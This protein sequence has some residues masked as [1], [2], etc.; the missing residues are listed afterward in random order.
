MLEHTFCHIHGIGRTGEQKLWDR[1]IHTWTD[2]LS[3]PNIVPR[4]SEHQIVSVLEQSLQAL[5]DDPMFFIKRLKHGDRWRIYPHFRDRIGYIDIETTGLGPGCDITT[6][7]LYDGNLV[8]T[9]VNGENIDDF[10]DDVNE[11]SMFVSFNGLSFDIPVI[12]HFFRI[13]LDQAHLDLRYVLS[14][15]GFKGGLKKCERQLGINRGSLDGI[16]G[17][18]AVL[19]WREYERTGS[20]QALETL[21]AYNIED[22]VN[23]E[24]LMVEAYNRNLDKT[25]FSPELQLPCPEPPQILHH[26]DPFIVDLIKS[27]T[28][29][30]RLT[31]IQF[32]ND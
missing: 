11:T 3:C 27:R 4:V 26:P 5:D 29:P 32:R 8:K 14:R 9:Y 12:E 21:L 1:G 23:L 10:V 17:S 24:R 20:K 25:P 6:I 22:T 13:T 31:E 16:D 19:L 28:E 30:A 7:S 2:L 18:F 15:M